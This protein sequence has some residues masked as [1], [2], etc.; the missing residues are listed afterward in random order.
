MMMM[1]KMMMWLLEKFYLCAFFD[2]GRNNR[3]H[4]VLFVRSFKD[5]GSK[6]QEGGR[7]GSCMNASIRVRTMRRR[8]RGVAW[9]GFWQILAMVFLDTAM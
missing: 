3:Q 6:E 7:G 1:K 9:H 5:G 4:D 2:K 8:R